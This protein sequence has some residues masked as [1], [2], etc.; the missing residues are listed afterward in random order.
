MLCRWFGHW[1]HKTKVFQVPGNDHVMDTFACRLCG[2][3]HE[4]LMPGWGRAD[5]L[6]GD[7]VQEVLLPGRYWDKE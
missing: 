1:W 6:S 2:K 3:Y 7:N 5:I 4:E